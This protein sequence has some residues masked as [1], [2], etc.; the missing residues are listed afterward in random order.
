MGTTRTTRT[1]GRRLSSAAAVPTPAGNGPAERH[2]TEGFLTRPLTG[3]DVNLKPLASK[4]ENGRPTANLATEAP[5]AHTADETISGR[6]HKQTRPT[7]GVTTDV[8]QRRTRPTEDEATERAAQRPEITG[9]TAEHG[10]TTERPSGRVTNPKGGDIADCLAAGDL[11]G[12]LGPLL[13]D[14]ACRARLF[15][16]VRLGNVSPANAIKELFRR[17]AR[18]WT[19]LPVHI[20]HHWTAGVVKREAGELT[21]VVFD[22]AP[23]P[24]SEA[25]ILT[26]FRALIIRK[27]EVISPF[28]QA[29]GSNECGLHLILVA[30]LLHENILEQAGGRQPQLVDLKPWRATL[31]GDLAARRAPRLQDL[32]KVVPALEKILPLLPSGG[33]GRQRTICG[34]CGEIAYAPS[35]CGCG[36]AVHEICRTCSVC[37]RQATEQEDAGRRQASERA[38]QQREERDQRTSVVRMHNPYATAAPLAE[39]SVEASRPLTAATTKMLSLEQPSTRTE[40]ECNDDG[41]DDDNDTLDELSAAI[42]PPSLFQKGDALPSASIAPAALR[43]EFLAQIVANSVRTPFLSTLGL[44][45]STRAAHRRTLKWLSTLP[46]Q[47]RELAQAPLTTFLVEVYAIT[48]KARNWKASTLV[49]K[50]AST[51]GALALLP[52]YSGYMPQVH[53]KLCPLWTQAVKGAG[54]R[55]RE[56]VAKQAKVATWQM[57]REAIWKEKN[58]KVRMAMLFAWMTCARVGCI[59]QLRSENVTQTPQGMS[60]QFRRGKS[61]LARGM[62]YTVHTCSVP[63]DFTKE[64]GTFLATHRG[65]LF[66]NTKGVQ[67]KNALRRV[68]PALE[69]R[70]LRRGSLQ[71]LAKEGNISLTEML[72]FSGHATVAM[73]RRYLDF[74][75][76]DPPQQ[77]QAAA[78]A[79]ESMC[80]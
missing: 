55:A 40:E 44:A 19:F 7:E 18:G 56:E 34:L 59:L 80:R 23:S 73:L 27:V 51:Q 70:S 26:V 72:N 52:L 75:R 12:L 69:Q 49:T 58:L 2:P 61:V 14:M 37:K 15:Y 13:G 57:V 74:G 1:K 38:E 48:A 43:G 6:D 42:L 64:C 53:L 9:E 16:D 31:A 8:R 60:V 46:A 65:N 39:T 41:D 10:R 17:S 68:D 62:A 35:R 67:I 28:K 79:A 76:H 3:E 78:E 4:C 30:L 66:N 24:A 45:A 5:T 54:R 22:S 63:T 32:V 21:A 36:V 71:T 33:G 50:M 77:A 11:D 47:N 25:D 20:R 29:R